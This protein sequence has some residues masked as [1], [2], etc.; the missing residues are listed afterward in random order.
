MKKVLVS[1]LT[2]VAFLFVA[3]LAVAK[4]PLVCPPVKVACT[5]T[6]CNLG[7]Q[8]C[9]A[10]CHE[11]CKFKLYC[12]AMHPIC[13]QFAYNKCVSECRVKHRCVGS[14]CKTVTGHK[15]CKRE[16]RCLKVVC[17]KAP[18]PPV[19]SCA[20]TTNCTACHF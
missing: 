20:T 15:V 11:Q 7:C 18:C 14:C 12:K 17:I 8:G 5:K 1:M 3:Q 10:R 6:V 4:T 19:C 2:V 13:G 16:V 9:Q